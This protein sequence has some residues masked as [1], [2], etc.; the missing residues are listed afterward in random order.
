M[1]VGDCIGKWEVIN[2]CDERATDG[3]MLIDAKRCTYNSVGRVPVL[4]T[5]SPSFKSK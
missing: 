3:H 2:I 1:K 4:Y 5:V